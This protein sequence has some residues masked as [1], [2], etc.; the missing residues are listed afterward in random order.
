[1]YVHIISMHACIYRYVGTLVN[2]H[3]YIHRYVVMHGIGVDE[4]MS[5]SHQLVSGRWSLPQQT[6]LGEYLSPDFNWSS[7]H[8]RQRTSLLYS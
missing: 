6:C 5:L 3:M 7:K 8:R 1:M 2:V 4:Q